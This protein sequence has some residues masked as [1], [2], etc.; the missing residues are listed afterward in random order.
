MEKI[1]FCPKPQQVTYTGKI[2]QMPEAWRARLPEELCGLQQAFR[3]VWEG[4]ET[5]SSGSAEISFVRK[6]YM[7]PEAYEIWVG[8]TG[9]GETGMSGKESG[10]TEIRAA[11]ISGTGIVI[12][13]A[14]A[15]G[16]FYGLATLH[17]MVCQCGKE[18]PCC[19]IKD[20]PGLKIR[21]VLLDISRGKVL[22]PDTL[23]ALADI[24]A[25]F[26]VNHLELYVE[27]FSFG[28]PSFPQVWTE[29]SCLTAEEIKEFS[30]YC[31][32]RFIDLVPHQN[33]LGHMSPWLA[34]KEFAHLAEAPE[35]L[36]VMGM[37]FPPTTMDAS[38]PG[39]LRLVKQ[40]IADL[41]GSFDSEYFHAGLDEAFEFCKGKNRERAG[42]EG[43]SGVIR[44][45]IRA[46][47]DF[48]KEKGFRMM[49]WDDFPVKYP[50]LFGELPEDICIMDWGYDREFPVEQ[51]AEMLQ[52]SGR[53]FCLCPGTSSWSSFTGLTDNMLEN[54]ERAG[55][56]AYAY[57]AEGMIVTD[58]G[59]K[60]HLQYQPVSYAGI[61]C[62]SAWAWNPL[63]ISEEELA[64]ALNR[65][66]FQ[67]SAERMGEFCL[68][69]GRFYE[70]EEF[71]MPC[72]S[73]A[74]LPLIFGRMEKEKYDKAV[75]RLVLAVRF[76]SPDE[77]C[78][79]Y[80]SSYENRSAFDGEKMYGFIRERE[81]ELDRVSLRCK[82]G[83]LIVREY[84][85]ALKMIRYL[86]KVRY[87]IETGNTAE[88]S[89]R[90]LDEIL[91]EHAELW[92]A[93]NKE[94]GLKNGM[95]MLEKLRVGKN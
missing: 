20:T 57:G 79:A 34:R 92:R 9:T 50:E 77:V 23:K 63:G 70:Q 56:A 73:L 49:M 59:D 1:I 25:S 27:G 37:K 62:A 11:G 80:I 36:D 35:G 16:A 65:F 94:S 85:N 66:V 21:G 33:S 54:V 42:K 71:R 52:K 40:L 47:H 44:P 64:C 12:G 93:R 91:K 55:K 60:N 68:G 58:W 26:K 43:E 2:R 89:D 17:Q 82:D 30:A 19:R 84:R 38:D 83:G 72:S 18:I 39:V 48:L 74:C 31:R 88:E 95:K 10:E 61:L 32:E 67:D 4:L 53:K 8:E 6:D 22:R 81:E 75:E 24:L 87:Q 90:L 28:Y 51:R 7:E 78:E 46:L 41:G 76:F 5:V 45:Y 3:S 69:A 86:T 13:Y 15:A 29:E 14:G